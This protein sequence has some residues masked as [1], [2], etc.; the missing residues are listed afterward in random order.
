MVA[1]VGGVLEQ[2]KTE[3][4]FITIDFQRDWTFRHVAFQVTGG[5]HKQLL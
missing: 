2:F 3:T 4:Y 1:G 5:D